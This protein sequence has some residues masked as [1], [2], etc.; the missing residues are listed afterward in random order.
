MVF[1]A[2]GGP[3]AEAVPNITPFAESAFEKGSGGESH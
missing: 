1:R 2:R 3:T